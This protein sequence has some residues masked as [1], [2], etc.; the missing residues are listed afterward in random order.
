LYQTAIAALA[1]SFEKDAFFNLKQAASKN[2][3]AGIEE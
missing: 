3:M 2:V 1:C